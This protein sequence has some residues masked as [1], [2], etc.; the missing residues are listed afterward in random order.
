M[1][2]NGNGADRDRTGDL[3]LAKQ[4]L[5]RLSYGPLY[6]LTTSTPYSCDYLSHKTLKNWGEN[7][8][9]IAVSLDHLLKLIAASKSLP[10]RRFRWLLIKIERSS[11][12]PSAQLCRY[13]VGYPNHLGRKLP[14][15]RV[16]QAAFQLV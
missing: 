15:V 4:A 2:R 10:Q 13:S 11:R 1:L 8:G 14:T 6:I 12:F 16:P 7:W 3:L 5:S 9:R